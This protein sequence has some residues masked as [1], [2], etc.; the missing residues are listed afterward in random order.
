MLEGLKYLMC[1]Q[2]QIALLTTD[3]RVQIASAFK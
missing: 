2:V 3:T 1:A